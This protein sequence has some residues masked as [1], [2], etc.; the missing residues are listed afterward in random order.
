MNKATDGRE[1]HS[2]PEMTYLPDGSVRVRFDADDPEAVVDTSHCPST[3]LAFPPKGDTSNHLP[4]HEEL[5]ALMNAMTAFKR[6][7]NL[8]SLTWDDVL[9]VLHSMGYRKIAKE[10]G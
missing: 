4:P 7:H 10:K 8:T 9:D 6:T 1:S 2:L 5:L 3:R